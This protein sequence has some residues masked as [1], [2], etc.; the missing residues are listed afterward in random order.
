M[1][2]NSG[3]IRR[4]KLSYKAEVKTEWTVIKESNIQVKNG[5]IGSWNTGGLASGNYTLRLELWVDNDAATPYQTYLYPSDKTMKLSR[6]GYIFMCLP[7]QTAIKE[8][9]R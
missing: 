9:A 4:Y 5:V 1:K 8:Q 2:E 7:I 3:N 6:E